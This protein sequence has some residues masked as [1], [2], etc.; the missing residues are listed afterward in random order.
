VGYTDLTAVPIDMSS[1]YRRCGD[2]VYRIIDDEAVVVRTNGSE[3]LGLNAV[4]ARILDLLDGEATVSAVL[5]A[6][7]SEY[8]VARAELEQDM[9][10][11]V[12]ELVSG[13][14]VERV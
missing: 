10:Q 7:E 2:V 11:F 13:G 12:D 5:D 6:L 9:Q 4:G 3:V 14:V 1:V 8:D